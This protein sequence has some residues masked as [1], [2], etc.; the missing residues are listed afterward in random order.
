MLALILAS[1]L[2]VPADPSASCVRVSCPLAG[3]G[4]GHGSGTVVASENGKSLIL[5]ARHVADD[6]F[7]TNLT[8]TVGDK[9][10]P[11]KL[12]AYDTASDLAAVE[13]GIE[14]PVVAV[15]AKCPPVGTPVRQ[16]GCTH[17][18]ARQFKTG[19]LTGY[20]ATIQ[21]DS[22]ESGCGVFAGN[23]LVAVTVGKKVVGFDQLGNP[24]PVPGDAQCVQLADVR[25]LLGT[26]AKRSGRWSGLAGLESGAVVSPP[27]TRPQP[28]FVPPPGRT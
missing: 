14:L 4:T 5:T 8:V 3:G 22:G 10:H 20:G 2:T 18:G 16:W 26:V 11:A 9:S 25:R 23:V 12:V 24:L 13:V 19:D 7:D 1:L 17:G 21:A 6:S 27:V 28:V 15:A